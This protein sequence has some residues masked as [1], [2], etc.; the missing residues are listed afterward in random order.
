MSK[1]SSKACL[2]G[3]VVLPE[4]ASVAETTQQLVARLETEIEALKLKS[5]SYFIVVEKSE[6]LVNK[7]FFGKEALEAKY[8][9]IH[10][11]NELK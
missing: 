8:L 5:D 10:K 1:G 2:L 7:E 11:A 4:Q 9:S 6:S 3:R